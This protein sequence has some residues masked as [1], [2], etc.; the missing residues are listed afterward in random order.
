[1]Y[2]D[3]LSSISNYWTDLPCTRVVSSPI[4][5]TS[6]GMSAPPREDPGTASQGEYLKLDREEQEG[7]KQTANTINYDNINVKIWSHDCLNLVFIESL[8]ILSVS[9]A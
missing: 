7:R 3:E 1:M 8:H 9:G 5:S 2:R 4:L 6:A